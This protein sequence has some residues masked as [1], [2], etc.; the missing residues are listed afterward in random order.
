MEEDENLVEGFEEND[1]GGFSE[2]TGEHKTISVEK[3]DRNVS[4]T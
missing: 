1:E 3:N 4:S 2:S